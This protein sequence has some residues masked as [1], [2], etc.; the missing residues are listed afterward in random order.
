MRFKTDEQRKAV[1]ANMNKFATRPYAGVVTDVL[2]EPVK[3]EGYTGA[4]VLAGSLRDPLVM[5]STGGYESPRGETVILAGEDYKRGI[6]EK[7]AKEHGGLDYQH[8]QLGSDENRDLVEKIAGAERFIGR[9][10]FSDAAQDLE[11]EAARYVESIRRL[12]E[13]GDPELLAAAKRSVE[14]V[15]KDVSRAARSVDLEQSA[16]DIKFADKP[17]IVQ[18]ETPIGTLQ[19]KPEFAEEMK[20]ATI[21]RV[22]KRDYLKGM[23]LDTF[24]PTK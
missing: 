19:A 21:K 2:A 22:P 16:K 4:E 11:A 24:D 14:K 9:P 17:K 15:S 7:L 12:E 8:M 1:M 20:T 5:T 10:V 18:M 23:K 6:L 3:A 13:S